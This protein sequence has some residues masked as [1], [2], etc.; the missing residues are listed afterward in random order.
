MKKAE[1][2]SVAPSPPTPPEDE[3]KRIRDWC[4]KHRC[5]LLSDFRGTWLSHA[6]SVPRT[7]YALG[8]TRL[9]SAPALAIV[10]T[11][12]A[13]PY[14]L[15]L[16]YQFAQSCAHDGLVIVSGLA[17][18]IDTYAHKGA[19][20]SGKTI[21]VLAHGLDQ[22]YPAE[23][24]NLAKAILEQGGCLLSEYPP[25]TP[26]LRH[27]FPLRNRIIATLGSGVLVV[28]A[29]LKSGALIT[30]QYA[31]DENREVF[32][33]PG[34]LHNQQFSGSHHLIQQGATLV[35]HPQDIFGAL[36]PDEKAR[37]VQSTRKQTEPCSLHPSAR[38]LTLESRQCLALF[39]A[40][41]QVTLGTLVALGHT[42]NAIN[43]ALKEALALGLI[44][45]R[46][47][48]VYLRLAPAQL[49]AVDLPPHLAHK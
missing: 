30:A 6:H 21:A 49:F 1:T 27:H 8:D 34:S 12:R 31:I 17:L 23:N 15:S 29:P 38:A 40:E 11:R 5:A 42:V 18:G 45:L 16:A 10:G 43:K 2:P 37:L 25:G 13:S 26:P 41:P 44:E 28:E 32:V 46:A 7:L 35:T 24:R 22:I 4:E 48:Q 36:A 3:E 39:H 9:L 19:L 14:G 20:A 33:A 47:P